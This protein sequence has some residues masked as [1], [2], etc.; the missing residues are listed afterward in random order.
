MAKQM[1]KM[2]A[3]HHRYADGVAY[4]QRRYDI[5][6]DISTTREPF[7]K[8]VGGALVLKDKA[9]AYIGAT[10][11]SSRARDIVGRADAFVWGNDLQDALAKI[12]PQ[13]EQ[14]EVRS[15]TPPAPPVAR[16]QSVRQVCTAEVRDL[17]RFNRR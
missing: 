15:Y 11:L 14:L 17:S 13:I 6:L 12:K 2:M 10:S 1:P 8:I 7:Y 16:R 9:I 4:N 3:K 5:M